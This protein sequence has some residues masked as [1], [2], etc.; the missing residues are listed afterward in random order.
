M[1]AKQFA[2]A[3]FLL[4]WFYLAY[5]LYQ[6]QTQPYE[7]WLNWLLAYADLGPSWK[8]RLEQR[9]FSPWHYQFLSYTLGLAWLISPYLF[10]RLGPYL[11]DLSRILHRDLLDLKT[12]LSQIP[13]RDYLL[14]SLLFGS[15]LALTLYRTQTHALQ[16]DEWWSYLRYSSR[17][18]V[19]SALAPHNN[20]TGYTVFAAFL[21]KL[22]PFLSVEWVL[23]LASII[24]SYL[25]LALLI[26][27]WRR[28]WGL[29]SALLFLAYFAFSPAFSF[30]GFYARAYGWVM[31][32]GGLFWLS[33]YA[34][35]GGATRFYPYWL[36]S[37]W[38]C[39][40][41]SFAGIWAVA[42]PLLGACLMRPKDKALWQAC[43]ILAFFTILSLAGP[44]LAGA[45][46]VLQEAGQTSA[47]TWSYAYWWRLCDWWWLGQKW[48]L[49][50]IYLLVAL[51][52]YR[53]AKAGEKAFLYLWQATPLVLWLFSWQIPHRVWCFLALVWAWALTQIW[54]KKYWPALALTTALL[55]SQHGYFYWSLAQDKQLLYYA[56]YFLEQAP[57]KVYLWGH[58]PK[59]ALE[60]Y[61]LSRGQTLI[62]AL[63]YPDSR[64]FEPW[65]P[66]PQYPY[67]LWQEDEHQPPPQDLQLL[68]QHYQPIHQQGVYSLWQY[69]QNP[70]SDDQTPEAGRN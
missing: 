15:A 62:L 26:L 34:W 27:L 44:I 6:A 18:M 68:Q 32:F 54:P 19:F 13:K 3:G 56:Q 9:I 36:L 67:L 52:I 70:A 21:L 49:T 8:P 41:A 60:A 55:T 17:G 64:N 53:Y 29:S 25:G 42:P 1:N 65:S 2:Q 30:Y 35:W 66:N 38:L 37:A 47:Q 50:W 4:L 59:P 51:V 58:Y 69:K 23:R 24:P 14:F 63:P 33:F 5:V 57:P 7:A 48:D 43:F 61:A 46:A 16:Y 31:V 12:H 10:H 45:F 39:M 11:L 28:L 22:L 20:H 40:Y